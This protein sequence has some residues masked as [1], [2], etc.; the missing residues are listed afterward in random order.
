MWGHIRARYLELICSV[1]V[2]NEHRGY[3][4]LDRILAAIRTKYPE[5]PAFIAR[6]EKHRADEYKHYVMF[7]RWFEQRGQMPYRVGTAGQ[8]DG[9]IEFLFGC[10][11]DTLDAEA[12]MSKP[13][14][15]AQL[16]HAI[17]LTERRG[18]R[19]VQDLMASPITQTDAHLMKILKVIERDEPSHWEPYEDWVK[20]HGEA[21]ARLREKLADSFANAGLMFV[22]FPLMLVNPRLPRR[23]D[24]PEDVVASPDFAAA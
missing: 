17:A 24:W 16:C 3:S 23:T 6:V 9:I 13:G 12:V 15:F 4:G 18:L 10:D 8:I 1:Y 20:E 22:K 7:K 5:D 2:Y 11:I 14:G 19:L 21:P